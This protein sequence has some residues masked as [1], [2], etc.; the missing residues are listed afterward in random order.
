MAAI[1]LLALSA[2]S[3]CLCVPP[4][5]AAR[6]QA[7]VAIV[8]EQG[9]A[10][11]VELARPDGEGTVAVM[12]RP[13]DQ[14]VAA[15]PAADAAGAPVNFAALAAGP[16]AGRNYHQGKYIVTSGYGYRRHPL[17]GQVRRHAG[18]DLAA[19]TGTAILASSAGRVRHA[20]W[21]GG[22]GLMVEVEHPGGLRTRYGHL[23]RLAVSAGQA[24]ARGDVIGFVGA[25]GRAT[26]PHLH[27]E[28]RAGQHAV[29]PL[30]PAGQ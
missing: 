19:S 22:Y 27:Y 20:G 10:G 8:L 2:L 6:A 17:S 4:G 11:A 30:P 7:G 21:S 14:A 25:T 28:V 3:A 5:G 23:S 15:S 12:A 9:D 29:N 26:G 24:I 1:R 18:V 16:V 13:D